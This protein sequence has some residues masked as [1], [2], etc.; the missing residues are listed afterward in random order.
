MPSQYLADWPDTEVYAKGGKQVKDFT[1]IINLLSY[2]S[3]Y[4]VIRAVYT[5]Y[6]TGL[7]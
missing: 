5:F 6:F 7:F 2:K 1:D 4:Y 3:P